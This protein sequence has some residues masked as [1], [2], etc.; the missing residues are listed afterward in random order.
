MLTFFLARDGDQ[1]AL[2]SGGGYLNSLEA[3]ICTRTAVS[4]VV[5]RDNQ[6]LVVYSSLS[7]YSSLSFPLARVSSNGSQ[8]PITKRWVIEL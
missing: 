8:I 5:T 7:D 3:M 4:A 1:D 2:S 6:L